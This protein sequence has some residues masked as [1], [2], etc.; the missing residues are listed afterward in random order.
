ME[1]QVLVFETILYQRHPDWNPILCLLEVASLR[2]RVDCE[3]DLI[4]P[5]EWMHEDR[6]GSHLHHSI[7]IEYE[8]ILHSV[9]GLNIRKSFLLDTCHVDHITC[10][11][12]TIRQCLTQDIPVFPVFFWE[13]EPLGSDK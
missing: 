4:D 6:S 7:C 5:R 1:K 11:Q 8:C 9:I 2:K 3:R 12:E 10:L 13:I